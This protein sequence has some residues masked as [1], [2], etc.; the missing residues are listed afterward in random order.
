MPPKCRN[1]GLVLLLEK[2]E[3]VLVC[4]CARFNIFKG[5]R[6]VLY[7]N[8]AFWQVAVGTSKG[9]IAS[10]S[11]AFIESVSDISSLISGA[12]SMLRNYRENSISYIRYFDV[13]IIVLYG[14]IKLR[15]RRFDFCQVC[16]LRGRNTF[17]HTL[18]R[19]LVYFNRSLKWIILLR[20]SIIKQ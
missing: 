12:P 13:F 8:T 4:G 11:E 7:W 14:S 6:V 16:R 17:G 1:S 15:L 9:K 3:N 5:S 18:K 2:L 19:R 10:V 20:L